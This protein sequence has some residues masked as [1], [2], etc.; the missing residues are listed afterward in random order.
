MR[1]RISSSREIRSL[2]TTYSSELNLLLQNTTDHEFKSI[3]I[4]SFDCGK[5]QIYNYIAHITTFASPSINLP[6]ILSL[7]TREER[8]CNVIIYRF[9]LPPYLPMSSSLSHVRDGTRTDS[10]NPLIRNSRL[11]LPPSATSKT[12]IKSDAPYFF[13]G[14]TPSL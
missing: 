8:G 7:S 3:K 11:A 10:S 5:L 14:T 13:T 12:S 9:H 6:Q 1:K 4:A 2:Q